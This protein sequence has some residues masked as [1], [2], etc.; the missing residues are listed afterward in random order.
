MDPLGPA[1]TDPT[2]KKKN[3]IRFLFNKNIKIR[4]MHWLC[5][6]KLLAVLIRQT[7][8]ERR[9]HCDHWLAFLFH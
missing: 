4:L 1:A 6:L 5:L 2:V 7:T 3:I 9:I 8:L